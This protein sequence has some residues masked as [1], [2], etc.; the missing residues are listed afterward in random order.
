MATKTISL[1]DDS[2][3]F[4][5]VGPG[6]CKREEEKSNKNFLIIFGGRTSNCNSDFI[7]V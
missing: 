2:L 4:H 3:V 5:T 1:L 7:A 6:R